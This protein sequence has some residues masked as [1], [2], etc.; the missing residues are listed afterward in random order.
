MWILII[1]LILIL[2]VMFKFKE[3]R[4]KIGLLVVT[5]ILLFL[6]FSIAQLYRS[7]SLDLT[8][9]DGIVAAGKIYF[10][11]LG[12]VFHNLVKTSSYVVQQ[13]W[14]LNVSNLG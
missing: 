9:F 7:H 11:W 13:N 1:L 10:S 14:G 2:I 5:G 3:I 4:H 8:S 12:N 6:I